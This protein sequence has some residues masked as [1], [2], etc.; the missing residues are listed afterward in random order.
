M[1]ALALD[2][3]RARSNGGYPGLVGDQYGKYNFIFGANIFNFV[4]DETQ[5]ISLVLGPCTFEEAR[6]S[7]QAT[8]EFEGSYESRQ[9]FSGEKE[10]RVVWKL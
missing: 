8:N 4:W 5:N 7:F 10:T 9:L 2:E 6:I 1:Y 3:E